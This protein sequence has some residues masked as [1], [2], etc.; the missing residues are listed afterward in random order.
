MLIYFG[1]IALVRLVA[2]ILHYC[3]QLNPQLASWLTPGPPSS[4]M[5]S[6]FLWE[7]GETGVGWAS[8]TLMTANKTPTQL[9]FFFL[10]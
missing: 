10:Q 6:L 2:N 8:L 5:K 3:I 1:E 9:F 7:R 4:E